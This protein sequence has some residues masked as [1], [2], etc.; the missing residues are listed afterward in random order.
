M[1]I[2]A[3]IYADF[4]GAL[5]ISKQFPLFDDQVYERSPLFNQTMTSLT[6]LANVIARY[7]KINVTVQIAI[8]SL[9][10][11]LFETVVRIKD[12]SLLIFNVGISVKSPCFNKLRQVVVFLK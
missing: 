7:E 6:S 10:N 4:E 9:V 3:L 1:A 8:N 5:L 2:D 11:A 12:K